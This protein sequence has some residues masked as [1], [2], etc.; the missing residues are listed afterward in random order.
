[1]FCAQQGGFGRFCGGRGGAV[2]LLFLAVTT[3]VPVFGL[4]QGPY[5]VARTSLSQDGFQHKGFWE[6]GR[7]Y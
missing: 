1:M 4:T 5:P 2:F 7:I 3:L 6:V